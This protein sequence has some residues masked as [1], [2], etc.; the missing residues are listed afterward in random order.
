VSAGGRFVHD[1]L[2]HAIFFFRSSHSPFVS[3]LRVAQSIE[4]PFTH[5]L[6]QERLLDSSR[7]QRAAKQHGAVMVSPHWLSECL[8]IKMRP[9]E[10]LFPPT[11]DPSRT[12]P[13]MSS[14]ASTGAYLSLLALS[15]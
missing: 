9:P 8:R 14:L 4:T 15:S 10:R 7:E 11:F 12:L 6:T 5:L 1:N 2:Y 13:D 3:G